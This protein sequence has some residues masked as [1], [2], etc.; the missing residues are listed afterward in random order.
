MN[1]FERQI[2][3]PDYLCDRHDRL[4]PWAAL[5]LCQEV[6]EGHSK[7]TGIGYET[8]I[9]RGLIWILSRA[10][11]IF[12]RRP[13]EGEEV[14]FRT[15]SRGCDGL[16]A[17]RDYEAMS[18]KG[19]CLLAGASYWPLIDYATRRPQRLREVLAGYDYLERTATKKSALEKLPIPTM[20]EGALRMERNVYYSMLDHVGHVNNAEYTRLIVDALADRG[21]DLDRPFGLEL[22]Y[23]HETLPDETL[24]VESQRH[25]DVFNI[26]ISNNRGTSVVAQITQHND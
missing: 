25:G 10:Y 14:V 21:L 26:L 4:H 11:Y 23:Q 18:S 6:S 3:I 19:E 24:V 20:G 16:F 13:Q 2:T 8:M 7:A 12:Y 17:W 5:R 15:W 9:Q 1:S 22:G